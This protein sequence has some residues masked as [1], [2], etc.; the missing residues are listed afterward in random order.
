ML[1]SL[2]DGKINYGATNCPSAHVPPHNVVAPIHQNSLMSTEPAAPMGVHPWN[3]SSRLEHL[4]G[5]HSRYY[6]LDFPTSYSSAANQYVPPNMYGQNVVPQCCQPCCRLRSQNVPKT[7]PPQVLYNPI[8]PVQQLNRSYKSKKTLKTTPCSEQFLSYIPNSLPVKYDTQNYYQPKYSSSYLNNANYC[9]PPTNNLWMPPAANPA[10]PPPPPPPPADRLRPI[11]RHAGVISHDYGRDKNYQRLPPNYQSNPYSDP[12]VGAAHHRPYSYVPPIPDVHDYRSSVYHNS[13]KTSTSDYVP[14]DSHHEYNTRIPGSTQNN[15]SASSLQQYY[16]AQPPTPYPDEQKSSDSFK[17]QIAQQNTSK[18]NNL[19]VREFLA[20]WDEGEEEIGEKT[21]ES[22]APIVVLDCMTLEGDALTKIQEKL[23]VVSYENLEKVLK[24]NQNPLILNTEPNEIDLIQKINSKPPPKSNFEPFDYTKRETGIIK[25]FITEKKTSPE[26]NSQPEKNY[27]VNFDGMVA[28]YGKKN[29]DISSTDL[30]ERLADRIFNLSKSQ[31]NEGV[32]FGTAAYTGQITQTSKPAESS[33]K[34]PSKYIQNQQMFD[35]HQ[36]CIEPSIIN[37]IDCA[38]NDSIPKIH[39]CVPNENKASI[40]KSNHPNSSCI[41][42]NVLKKC[43]NLSNPGEETTPWNLDQGTQE[44]HLNMSLYDHSVIIKPLDFSSL[45]DDTKGNPFLFEKNTSNSDKPINSINDQFNKV[46]NENNSYNHVVTENQHS[47]QQIDSSNRNFPVIV[48]PNVHRQEYNGFHESV[49]QRTGCDKNKHD[50]MSGQNDF[51][52]MNWNISNDLDKIM[53]NTNMAMEPSCLYDRNNYIL[54]SMNTDRNVTTQWKDNIPCVD[55]T[56][57]SKTNHSS[58]DSF[59]DGWNFIENYDNHSGKKNNS[60]PSNNE[61][62]NALFSNQTVPLEKLDNKNNDLTV[63][64]EN[65]TTVAMKNISFSK[66]NEISTKNN[67]CSRDVFNLNNRIP[68]FGDSFELP[69]I[70]EPPDY[71][72]PKKT[73]GDNEHRTDGSIFEHLTDSKCTRNES[74]SVK[75]DL[76]KPDLAGLPSFKEKEPLA[77]MP[78]PPKLNIVKPIIRN[79]S[80]M[81]TVIKQKLKYDNACVDTDDI[82]SNKTGHCETA[83]A[84]GNF[85]ETELKQKLNGAQLNQFDVWSE[86]FVLKGNSNTSSTA[87]VQCDVEITQFKSTPENRNTSIPKPNTNESYHDKST[88]SSEMSEKIAVV[89]NEKNNSNEFLSCLESTKMNDQKYRDTLDEFETSFGFDIHCNNEANKSFHEE[90]V[91][92]C[93]EER[94]NDEICEHDINASNSTNAPNVNT[95]LSDSAQLPFQCDFQSGYLIKNYFD[96]NKNKAVLID[97]KETLNHDKSDATIFNYHNDV[98]NNFELEKNKNIENSEKNSEFNI[99]TDHEIITPHQIDNEDD[100]NLIKQ[101]ELKCPFQS[102]CKNT[103][104]DKNSSV[105]KNHF[106]YM[107]VEDNNFEIDSSEN[108]VNGLSKNTNEIIEVNSSSEIND[109]CEINYSGSDVHTLSSIQQKHTINVDV[110]FE[111]NVD[112]SNIF[113]ANI[114][115]SSSKNK[116]ET[117]KNNEIENNKNSFESTFHSDEPENIEIGKDDKYIFELENNNSDLYH[118]QNLEKNHQFNFEARIIQNFEVD[119]NVH[120]PTSPKEIINEKKADYEIDYDENNVQKKKH[121]QNDSDI[122]ENVQ[123]EQ[124]TCSGCDDNKLLRNARDNENNNEEYKINNIFDVDCIADNVEE[125][126]HIKAHT[127][128]VVHGVNDEEI[129]SSCSIHE[130]SNFNN[131]IEVENIFENLYD[132]LTTLNTD[133]SYFDISKNDCANKNECGVSSVHKHIVSRSLHVKNSEI[134]DGNCEQA[135]VEECIEKFDEAVKDADNVLLKEFVS[136]SVFCPT[137]TI[138]RNDSIEKEKHSE[139]MSEECGAKDSDEN[140]SNNNENVLVVSN[141]TARE[142]TTTVKEHGK[143]VRRGEIK[144]INENDMLIMKNITVNTVQGDGSKK[145]FEN[146]QIDLLNAVKNINETKMQN[147]ERDE[148]NSPELVPSGYVEPLTHSEHSDEIF[149]VENFT[150]SPLSVKKHIDTKDD[151]RLENSNFISGAGDI[152]LPRIKFILKCH[153]KSMIKKNV[154]EEKS[155][156]PHKKLNVVKDDRFIA[157]NFLKKRINFYKPWRYTQRIESEENVETST[158][159][160]APENTEFN[161]DEQGKRVENAENVELGFENERKKFKFSEQVDCN[162]ELKRTDIPEN[163]GF[164]FNDKGQ[165]TAEVPE[166]VGFNFDDEG[167]KAEVPTEHVEIDFDDGRNIADVRENVKFDIDDEENRLGEVSENVDLDFGDEWKSAEVP[168]EEPRTLENDREPWSESG[169]ADEYASDSCVNTSMTV[170]PM[171]SPTDDFSSGT[172]EHCGEYWDKSLE[173]EYKTVLYKTIS[174]LAKNAVNIRDRFNTRL[175]AARRRTATPA[176]RK[177]RRRMDGGILQ[178]SGHRDR[179]NNGGVDV[180]VA[181]ATVTAV[182]PTVNATCKIK[183]QLPWGRIFNLNEQRRTGR[184]SED[185][186]HHHHRRHQQHRDTKL[187]LG[188]AKVEVRLSRTPGEWQ[189]CESTTASKSVQVSV[190]RLVLQ[191][192]ISPRENDEVRKLPKIVIR[193]NG[194]DNYTSYVSGGGSEDGGD[195]IGEDNPRLTVRLV[196]DRTL[197]EMAANG[198]TTLHLKHYLVPITESDA[199]Q[200]AKK[201]RYA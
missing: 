81:Y 97:Q 10:W 27:S 96:E 84:V 90:I 23:N 192:A 138:T 63:K 151:V 127:D 161:F 98:E 20:T 165:K 72:Q 131:D 40:I 123:N 51:E 115:T 64:V 55:L 36:K 145:T 65:E 184:G 174:K 50:K 177:R 33:V 37:K 160:S 9:P 91:D 189:V 199:S 168:G 126:Q 75:N 143:D 30:I 80:H 74:I 112:N 172:P 198:V 137:A 21:S 42:E 6:N 121:F 148:N 38:N 133:K 95:S 35:L 190:K 200:T 196:R 139:S 11:S 176:K 14:Y 47:M 102:D 149:E 164:D 147:N 52:S 144:L 116:I 194:Q 92:K 66:P 141:R 129:D 46:L 71:M 122:D 188:P 5:F 16:S 99:I 101:T 150:K 201:V 22:A 191:R 125:N 89:E 182:E 28:W 154:F 34:D 187:E 173:N 45:T 107:T 170:T 86:K 124:N 94:I 130:N 17:P 31:E 83:A 146:T 13:L 78:V 169:G 119:C 195:D 132:N 166:N 44:Q 180:V 93:L 67:E 108:S 70:S 19:N 62:Q 159:V 15:H 61:I 24:E 59:F 135:K 178:S 157:G 120:N 183:V 41:V 158:R 25:P 185:H 60:L 39:S 104:T 88:K 79:P 134:V 113:E 56:V 197:D 4:Y 103:N 54:D 162:D 69:A 76:N 58:H 3:S 26:T 87:V 105:E 163:L 114:N 111:L 53:K 175:M 140:E 186:H 117:N 167:K 7:S 136:D 8:R 171:P 153:S 77:P 32:S 73:F 193:R 68:D 179:G 49:I 85:D 152:I 106:D 48:S 109:G 2:R 128:F 1:N 43:L 156:A 110:D 12:V 118:T 100:L 181:P 155:I 57:N 29:T 142:I 82:V 18:T